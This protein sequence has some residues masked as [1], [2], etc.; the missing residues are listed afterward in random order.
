MAAAFVAVGGRAAYCQPNRSNSY[1]ARNRSRPAVP[2]TRLG[3]QASALGSRVERHGGDV[4]KRK[5]GKVSRDAVAVGL[6]APVSIESR[7]A[8]RRADEGALVG[9]R[10]RLEARLG[11]GSFGVV[12]RSTDVVTGEAVAVKRIPRMTSPKRPAEEKSAK[13]QEEA[14]IFSLVQDCAYVCGFRGLETDDEYMYL[15]MELIDGPSLDDVLKLRGKLSE[16]EAA[17][18]IHDIL[19]VVSICHGHGVCHSDVKPANFLY[20]PIKNGERVLK[21]IDFGCSQQVS[22]ACPRL[23]VANGT[24]LYSSPEVYDRCY[25]TEADLWSCGVILFRAL[26]GKLPFW[27]ST[28]GLTR[29]MVVDGVM[30]EPVPMGD[31]YWGGVSQ[32]ARDLCA[33][34]LNR[35]RFKRISANEAIALPWVQQYAGSR[36]VSM[37][38]CVV[39]H[40]SARNTSSDNFDETDV[41]FG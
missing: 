18:M 15:A 5:T 8:E 7:E 9:G 23:S 24:P 1:V 37:D 4:A 6:E 27:E 19:Q 12:F 28:K 22:L 33:Q 38:T 26:T 35:N 3:V 13:V 39:S 14:R 29:R 16:R 25:S 11:E 31:D 20:R 21:A 30:L 2:V 36:D 34:L 32:E 41:V 10:Y 40:W 17:L